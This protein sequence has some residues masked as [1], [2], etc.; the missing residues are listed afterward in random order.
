[1][2]EVHFNNFIPAYAGVKMMTDKNIFNIICC[3]FEN[4]LIST[5]IKNYHGGPDENKNTYYN[6]RSNFS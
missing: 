5:V 3:G 1:M 4:M 6:Y 2:P